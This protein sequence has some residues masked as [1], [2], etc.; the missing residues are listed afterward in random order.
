MVTPDTEQQDEAELERLP[1][2]HQFV[3][4]DEGWANWVVRKVVE[5]RLYADRVE[6]WAAG[7]IRRAQAEERYF[8]DRFGPQLEGWVRQELAA[9]GGRARSVKLPA[10]QLGFRSVPA[11]FRT[12][13]IEILAGWCRHHLPEAFRVR[14]DAQGQSA[15]VLWTL[16]L[17]HKL[18]VR[19][20]EGV[21][22]NEVKQHIAST[23]EVPPGMEAIDGSDRFFIR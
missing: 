2:P 10:G 5:A 14:V 4:A 9:R 17:D 16:L 15:N 1:V 23:G 12:T 21:L 18:D 20:E 22:T 3:V 8:L 11:S 19:V 13:E 7:E 6:K